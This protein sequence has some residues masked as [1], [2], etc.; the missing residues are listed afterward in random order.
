MSA[1]VVVRR[2]TGTKCRR[3]W[4]VLPE[5]GEWKSLPDL[6]L[7][8]VDAVLLHDTGEGLQE[9]AMRR[10]DQAYAAAIAAGCSPADAEAAAGHWQDGA[11]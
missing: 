7:R 4:K 2:A 5:I 3:C 1:T 11:R 9:H 10:F 6:C 8:C